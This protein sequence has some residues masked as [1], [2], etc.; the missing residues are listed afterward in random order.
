MIIVTGGAGFIGSNLVK[1]LNRIGRDDVVVVDNLASADKFKNIVDCSIYDYLDKREFIESLQCLSFREKIETVFHQG[2]CSNTMETDGHYM[3][4]N[5]YQYSKRLF[6][7]CIERDIPLIYASSASVYGGGTAFTESPENENALNIYAY[8]KLLFDRFVRARMIDLNA[9]VVGLRYFNVYGPGETHKGRMASV[10]HHF[11][12]QFLREG[13]VRLFEGTDGYHD[14]EQKRDFV[15]IGDV[16]DVNLYFL[17]HPDVSGI[18]NVGT[19]RSRTF[20]SM[21]TAVINNASGERRSTGQL[22]DSGLIRYIEFPQILEGK[23]QSFTQADI[24]ALESI[25]CDV[26]FTSLDEGVR[27]YIESV[28]SKQRVTV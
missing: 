28:R 14:G 8:S 26:E 18:F 9:Q 3:M 15:W 17:D 7:F 2:A 6:Q 23:Y 21:A 24:S 10:A 12:E 25:G 4:V 27:L 5:N 1:G 11:Y 22:V 16:V 20:N 19:G 13:H